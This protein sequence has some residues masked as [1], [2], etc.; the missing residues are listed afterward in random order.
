[1]VIESIHL[2]EVQLHNFQ[3]Q[4]YSWKEGGQ[5]TWLSWRSF[6]V[7][8]TLCTRECL[9]LNFVLIICL[10]L[11]FFLFPVTFFL[12]NCNSVCCCITYWINNSWDESATTC[13]L[14]FPFKQTQQLSTQTFIERVVILLLVHWLTNILF[15]AFS[16]RN[17]QLKLHRVSRTRWLL[18]IRH[19]KVACPSSSKGQMQL[20]LTLTLVSLP[21]SNNHLTLWKCLFS[22]H[23]W[24]KGQQRT[25]TLAIHQTNS[26]HWGQN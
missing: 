10:P 9:L 17:M 16:F 6:T 1:M 14:F 5:S 2:E 20:C 7:S 21:L 23:F 11:L 12:A 15:V 24:L 19:F 13:N 22:I 26:S 3:L 18:S 4:F 8:F 25:F